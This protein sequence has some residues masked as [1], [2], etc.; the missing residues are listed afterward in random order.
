MKFIHY[1]DLDKAKN[2]V[3]SAIENVSCSNIDG[4]RA[5]D[6]IEDWINTKIQ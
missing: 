6:Q 3:L 2:E 5:F 1:T 4:V